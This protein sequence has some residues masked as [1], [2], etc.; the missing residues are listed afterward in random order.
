VAA[1]EEDLLRSVALKNANSILLARQRAEES[2]EAKTEELALSLS[3]MQA[4]LEATTD[5][6]LVTDPA[7][8]VTHFNVQ[9]VR[10]WQLHEGILQR[11]QHREVLEFTSRQFADP[12]AFLA[13]I[14]EIYASSQEVADELELLDGRVIERFSKIQ[15]LDDRPMGRVWS[16]RDITDRKLSEEVRFRLAAVVESSDDAIISKSLQGI[17]ST[18][19]SG[20]ERMF[21]YSAQEAVG[22][23]ITMLL[24]PGREQDELTI[25]ERIRRGQ[26]IDHFETERVRKDGTSIVVSLTI[27]PI[28]DSKGTIIGASKIARDITERR[29]AEEL[30]R[31]SESDLRTL[32][33]SIPH[34]AWMANPDGYIFWYNR[35][36]YDYT[37][38]TPEEMESWGW[39]SLH[40]PDLLPQVTERWNR[41]LATGEPFEMEFPLRRADGSFRWFLTRTNPL[42]DERG[43]IVRW[44]GTNT[45]VDDVKR[46]EQALR[47]ESRTLELLNET[48]TLI[49]STLDM[50]KLL[51]AVTD[52]A[53]QLSGATFGAFFYHNRNSQG[54]AYL[55]YTLSGAPLE[56]FEKFGH[57]RATPLFGLTFKDGRPLRSDDVLADPRYGKMAPHFGMPEGHLPVR[58]YLA[59]PVVL[60]TGEVLGG[61]F[62]GHPECGVFTQR[63]ERIVAGVAAQ[64]AVAIDNA[65]LYEGLQKASEEREQLLE[66]ERVARSEAERVS[67]MKDEFLATLS[68]EL[69]TP[70]NAILGWSQI[71]ARG[72]VNATDLEQGLEVIQRNARAQA[73]LIEDLLDMSRIIS[74]KVRLDV[75]WTDLASVVDSAVDSV[76]PSADA[77]GIRLRKILDPLAGPVSGDPTRLQQVVWNLLSNAVKFT[78]KGGKVDVLLQRVNSHLEITV[79][80]TGM[81]IKAEFLPVVFERFRQADSSTTRAYGGLGLG[82]SIVKNLVELHGGTIRVMSE[83]E[84][85]GA[86]F[87]VSLPLAPVRRGHNRE[88]PTSPMAPTLNCDDLSL[89]GVKV[90]VVDDEPDAQAMIKRMLVQCRAEVATA[91]TADEG[92]QLLRHYQPDVLVSDIGMPTKDGYQFIRD[93]RSL[94]SREGGKTP[95]IAL[96]A[97]ARSEDRTRAMIA[98][99]QIHISKPIEPAEL[100]ATIG[101]LARGR[102]T[103][104]E[105]PPA[106]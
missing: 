96:T 73:Q 54:D 7:G 89:A 103:R 67:V 28:K 21:G 83:G 90:L 101:S 20:A 31:R 43:H 4:T 11:R 92:L 72:K 74:G 1:N 17:I 50:K 81:G 76:R 62:F 38:R 44:F 46:V 36:W 106:R 40:R 2:V 61:L 48:G 82:L 85:T 15:L 5:A 9:Y 59:V 34:L 23:P 25:L 19:N 58:S 8:A 37:G 64:A 49:G 41:S 60:R 53:T 29:R 42:R 14:D 94:P 63:T 97:F 33:N 91:G 45:D 100:V 32:A 13:R 35:G 65:R 69:R 16:F 12:A 39:Q 79:H 22:H 66:A 3:L 98:G 30:L 47:D 27:S 87:V 77:K 10:M 88:H 104:P 75:Q 80:D 26:H 52:A 56:A 68:H 57:P 55:L 102:A 99:Y 105:E 95:A 78:P 93:V 71:L 86:T 18:W 51:Q 24:P 70:L 84:G 6:I